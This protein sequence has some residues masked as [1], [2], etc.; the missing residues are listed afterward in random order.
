LSIGAATGFDQSHAAS[1]RSACDGLTRRHTTPVLAGASALA[2][3][4]FLAACARPWVSAIPRLLATPA[5]PIL[6][7]D[8]QPEIPTRCS[9]SRLPNW[10]FPSRS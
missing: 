2:G 10:T 4:Q 1:D 5:F 8:G 9:R 6:K 7:A 3:R